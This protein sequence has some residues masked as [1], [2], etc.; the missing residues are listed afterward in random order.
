MIKQSDITRVCV[1]GDK[2]SEQ[3]YSLIVAGLTAP[4]CQSQRFELHKI[5]S[6]PSVKWC[7]QLKTLEFMIFSEG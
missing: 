7:I 5:C 6:V 1:C 2:G 4:A 3:R